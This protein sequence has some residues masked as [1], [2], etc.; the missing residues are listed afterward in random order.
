MNQTHK[1]LLAEL[2]GHITR[3]TSGYETVYAPPVKARW[4]WRLAVFPENIL[5]DLVDIGMVLATREKQ[6]AR[7]VDED[8][9]V[10]VWNA[11]KR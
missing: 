6:H 7:H 5:E 8:K 10:E 4:L 11:T 9:Q 2:A 3:S 1:E